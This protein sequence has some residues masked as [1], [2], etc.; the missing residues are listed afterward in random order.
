MKIK[1]ANITT[2]EQWNEVI[3][4]WSGLIACDTETYDKEL[5]KHLLGISLSPELSKGLDGIYIPLKHFEDGKFV[6]VAEQALVERLKVWLSDQ[7][8][9]GHNFTYDKG[10][11]ERSL[12]I[13]TT[14]AV[15]TRIMWHLSAAPAGPKPYGLKD[16]QIELLGWSEKGDTTLEA[17]V[18]ARGGKLKEGDHYLASLE[19]LSKYAILDAFSTLGIYC[20][21]KSFFDTHN[22]WWMLEKI[23]QY[24]EL[25]QK[26]TDL[27]ILVDRVGL[28]KTHD[29]LLKTKQAA[30]NR[31][32]KELSNVIHELET[33]WADRKVAL[34]KRNY[35]K[36]RYLNHPE[37]WKKF[38]INSDKDK[39]ELFF[40]KLKCPVVET[41]ESGLASTG[42][43]NFKRVK[44]SWMEAYLKY[45]HANTISTN[46]SGPYL[47]H[48][49]GGRLHP[50]FNICGTV[51]YRLSGFKPYLLNAPFDEKAVLRHLRVDE[52]YIGIHSDLSAIE[53]TITAHFSEDPSL[54]KVFRDGLGDIYLDLALE[55]FPN[56]EELHEGYNPHVQITGQTKKR[57]ERQR[58]VA[59]VIQLAVQYTGTGHTVAKNLNKEGIETTLRQA[60][61]MV[62]VYWRK[63]AAVAD[64]NKRLF[65]L[66]RKQGYLRNVIG[67]IIQVPHPDYKDL[68]NRFVQS[69]AHDVLVLWVLEIYR[70][71][72]ERSIPIKPTLFDCHDSSSNQVPVEFEHKA[73]TVYAEALETI[74][75][76]L[77]LCV[78]IKAETK[79]F[80]TLAGLKNEE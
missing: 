40:D 49:A 2:V 47:N 19:T 74:N 30:E 37:E 66:N 36:T 31:F 68:P 26:N 5:G 50:G 41:T 75:R 39:R 43:D 54:L 22:Y 56:D 76:Q 35:N 45:E 60:E 15:D 52:G 12:N 67:R 51:S 16:A 33:D 71:A 13:R 23:M 61:D 20:K 46:F 70:L 78:T 14:W 72:Q 69:S 38:N 77:G 8:L 29:R 28:Q 73:K 57:F 25:L 7:L 3:C 10:W 48:S 1:G 9:I 79:T 59:K 53:P 18:K 55:L 34:Y 4:T 6:E 65:A 63:F 58:K 64:L 42:A 17:E 21:L 80:K 27:G 11:L 32:R 44:T 62:R 24:N